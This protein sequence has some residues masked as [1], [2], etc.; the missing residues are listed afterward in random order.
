MAL[1]DLGYEGLERSLNAVLALDPETRAKL[2]DC[3][4][5]VVRIE[6]DGLATSLDLAVSDDGSLQLV[7][8]SD[9]TPDATLAGSPFDLLRARDPDKG[10]AQL[11][12]GRVRLSG[13]QALARQFSQALAGL[14]IDWEEHLARLIGDIP[15]HE[16]GRA[17]RALRRE[18]SR[19]SDSGGET[20]SDYL[21]EELRLLPHRYEAGDFLADVDTL[22][23]DVDR[24][25][26]RI[27]LL[28]RHGSDNDR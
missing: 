25:E 12:A 28:E 7:N 24:L 19:L 17:A 14:D 15:A 20:L 5:R 4:G 8:D 11:F 13:D 26:A 23:D 9:E 22:R 2:A 21:T 10:V 16:L 1:K 18:G 27:R 3:Q 6:L